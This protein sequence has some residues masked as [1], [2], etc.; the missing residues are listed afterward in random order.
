MA[1]RFYNADDEF[2][3]LSN[4]S[5]HGFELDGQFWPTVEHFYQAQ[6]FAAPE[7]RE[8]IRRSHTPG[9]AKRLAWRRQYPIRED[10][11][12]VR[13]EVMQRALAAKFAAHPALADAL[14]ATGDEE[15]VEASPTD[16]YWGCGADGSGRNRLGEL[17]MELRETLRAAGH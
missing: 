3:F 17:L 1:I 16:R 9:G 8:A 15:L 5:P 12:Q 11:D 13:D 7:T 2:G 10:W 14:L 6:K 4:F